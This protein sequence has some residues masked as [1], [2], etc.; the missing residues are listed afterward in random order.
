MTREHRTDADAAWID[1][2][3]AAWSAASADL[4]EPPTWVRERAK[5]LMAHQRIFGTSEP[6]TGRLAERIRA[7]LVFDSRK[8]DF[9]NSSAPVGNQ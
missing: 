7:T 5:R 4:V 8:L 9:W 1:A 6:N 2:I 3:R